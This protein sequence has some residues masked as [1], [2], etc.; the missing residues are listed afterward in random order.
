MTA[1]NTDTQVGDGLPAVPSF[2]H[3]AQRVCNALDAYFLERLGNGVTAWRSQ[4]R[5]PVQLGT[6]FLTYDG[7][8]TPKSG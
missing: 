3:S 4:R 6:V 1:A 7:L 8:P 2:V 5:G